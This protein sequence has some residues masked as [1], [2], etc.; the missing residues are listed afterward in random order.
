MDTGA[1]TEY[2]SGW[3]IKPLRVKSKKLTETYEPFLSSRL[4]AIQAFDT[5]GG[6]SH[7]TLDILMSRQRRS[8]P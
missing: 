1:H 3:K 2:I 4:R 6:F 7:L 5:R 8:E